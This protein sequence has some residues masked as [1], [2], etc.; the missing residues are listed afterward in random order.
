MA[1]SFLRLTPSPDLAEHVENFWFMRGPGPSAMPRGHWI[2][3]DGC[4]EFVF[5]LEDPFRERQPD[6]TWRLQ[7]HFLLVGQMEHR[8]DVQPSGRI[9]AVGVHFRPAGL[10]AFVSGDLSRFT[11]RIHGLGPAIGEDLAPLGRR[12]K[13]RQRTRVDCFGRWRSI[14]SWRQS[15][16]AN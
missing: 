6:G 15:K 12:L 5:Q 10:A 14:K 13:F 16:S 11:D 7:G 4:M 3:P 9:H 1:L 2:L 8:V